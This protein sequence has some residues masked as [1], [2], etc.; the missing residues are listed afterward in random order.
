[1]S[2][3]RLKVTP[4]RWGYGRY[5]RFA[6]KNGWKSKDLWLGINHEQWASTGDTPIWFRCEWRQT[7]ASAA[8]IAGELGVQHSGLWIPVH[9][10]NGVE[11]EEVLEGASATL[12]SIASYM[13]AELPTGPG[14]GSGN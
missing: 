11:Y 3:A 12:K 7:S 13:G 4:Q 14:D 8:A 10:P 2:I 5:F 9:L 1:M 6:G